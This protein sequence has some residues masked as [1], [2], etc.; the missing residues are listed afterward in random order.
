MTLCNYALK[1][2]SDVFFLSLGR[3]PLGWWQGMEELR[4]GMEE[5]LIGKKPGR[6]RSSICLSLVRLL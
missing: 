3:S 4:T 5:Y 1:W 2:M 6:S